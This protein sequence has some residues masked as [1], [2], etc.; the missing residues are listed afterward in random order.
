MIY[1]VDR[2][3]SSNTAANPKFGGD[4]KVLLSSRFVLPQFAHSLSFFL[5]FFL[6]QSNR[7]FKTSHSKLRI[8]SLA[9]SI[10]DAESAVPNLKACEELCKLT[11]NVLKKL[12]PSFLACFLPSH[13][14]I[15][16]HHIYFSLLSCSFDVKIPRLVRQLRPELTRRKTAITHIHER[17]G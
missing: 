6:F 9:K 1:G 15:S 17:V 13:S 8:S 11:K 2:S 3:E 16:P 4:L 10:I 5:S 12:L 14:Y 7:S